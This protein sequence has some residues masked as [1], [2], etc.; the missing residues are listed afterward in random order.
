MSATHE[1]TVTRR[2]RFSVARRLVSAKAYPV[3]FNPTTTIEYRLATSANVDIQIIRFLVA[4]INARRPSSNSLGAV[5]LI[6]KTTAL[7][8]CPIA[9]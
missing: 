2:V 1:V 4:W 5:F 7:H 3:P 9:Y 8:S 6:G